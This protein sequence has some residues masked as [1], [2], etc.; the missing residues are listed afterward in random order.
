M[1]DLA[2]NAM[3]LVLTPDS[4]LQVY[5]Q[6]GEPARQENPHIRLQENNSF[7]CLFI[8]GRLDLSP[9]Q[10]S[11][12]DR[13]RLSAELN[14]NLSS[15]PNRVSGNDPYCLWAAPNEWWVLA[16][17]LGPQAVVELA[18]HLAEQLAGQLRAVLPETFTITDITDSRCVIDISGTAA[19]R[20]LA[21]GCGLD[22]HPSVFGPGQCA[23]TL[24]NQMDV[25][26]QPFTTR[27]SATPLPATHIPTTRIPATQFSA[28]QAE[29][30]QSA[31]DDIAYRMLVDRSHA[32]YCWRWLADA[33]REFM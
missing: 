32:V 15:I 18:E 30:S 14:I 33:M 21:T 20:L 3:P 6:N 4:P 16:S 11:N 1:S 31:V 22:F 27:S 5:W 28:T 9:A 10:E 17:G 29:S 26:I 24:F 2:M 19:A 12:S 7:A 23:Q 25:V 8:Q 13:D